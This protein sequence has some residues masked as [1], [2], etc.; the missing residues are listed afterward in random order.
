[1]ENQTKDSNSVKKPLYHRTANTMCSAITGVAIGILL[2]KLITG[3]SFESF[4]LHAIGTVFGTACIYS[5]S[6][7]LSVFAKK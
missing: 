5:I 2:M 3:K 4:G 1:M 7:L 6:Y